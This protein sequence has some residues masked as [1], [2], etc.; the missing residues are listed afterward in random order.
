MAK[1]NI[2]S[3]VLS[4]ADEAI[5]NDFEIIA[6]KIFPNTRIYDNG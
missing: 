3:I 2:K 6:E 1:F 5:D 4:T